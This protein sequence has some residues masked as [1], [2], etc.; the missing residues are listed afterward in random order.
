MFSGGIERDKWHEKG[1]LVQVISPFKIN[2]P[3]YIETEAATGG[4]L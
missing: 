2:T 3:P 1:W 4:A